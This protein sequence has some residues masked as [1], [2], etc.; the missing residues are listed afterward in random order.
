MNIDKVLWAAVVTASLAAC[1]AADTLPGGSSSSSPNSSSSSSS[2]IIGS[3]S[4]TTDGG[5]AKPTGGGL[6]IYNNAGKITGSTLTGAQV[7]YASSLQTLIS[8]VDEAT[9]GD[10]PFMIVYSGNEDDRINQIINDHTADQNGDCPKGHWGDEYRH[11]QIKDYDAGL[12][13]VGTDGSSANF[14]I[15]INK[16]SNVI[17]QNMK[18]GALAS[19]KNDADMIRI[20]SDKKEV[21]DFW[22]DHNELFA[23][24][25]ECNGSPDGDLTFEAAL[26]IK[27]RVTNITISYNYIHDSKKVGVDGFSKSDTYN[28]KITFHHNLYRNVNGRL[29][30]Q[31]SGFIHV[32]NNYYSNITGSGINVRTGGKALIENNWFEDAA[33]PV[34]CRFDTAHCGNWQ[35]RNNNLTSAADNATYNINWTSPGSGGINADDWRSTASFTSEVSYSYNPNSAQCVKD[36]LESVVGVGKNAAQLNCN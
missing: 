24:N 16:S 20:E 17:V 4:S 23:V 36:H 32:Y 15:R 14:G 30:L 9:D 21:S 18:I 31:R 8:H 22:I 7:R 11:V 19:A 34:T 3:T 6:P 29:P 25:N 33:N 35:L 26:D 1:G 2:P 27:K 5:F 10:T 28:R 13:I 12:T